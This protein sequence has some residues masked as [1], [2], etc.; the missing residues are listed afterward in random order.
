MP[1]TSPDIKPTPARP[2][3]KVASKLRARLKKHANGAGEDVYAT[4][5]VKDYV[6][7]KKAALKK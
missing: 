5:S 2:I 7:R 1:K 3:D 4:Q 6:A